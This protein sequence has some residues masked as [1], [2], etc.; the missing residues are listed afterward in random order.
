MDH[1][2]IDGHSVTERYLDHALTP[3]ERTEFEAHLVDCQE[4]TD[5]LL[6]AEMFHNR[7]G[8]PQLKPPTPPQAANLPAAVRMRPA[9]AHTRPMVVRMRMARQFTPWQLFRILAGAAAVAAVL[10]IA[11]S[12]LLLWVL[13]LGGG[14][15]R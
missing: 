14:F 11:M 13:A 5:R 4:C 15:R 9:A 2:Y 1:G 7:N 6:L 8:A 12:L 10:A 3:A